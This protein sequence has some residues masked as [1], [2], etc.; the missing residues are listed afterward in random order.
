[1]SDATHALHGGTEH[2]PHM[3]PATGHEVTHSETYDHNRQPGD[4]HHDGSHHHVTSMTLLFGVFAALVVL[5]VATV[6]VT[7][8][9]FGYNANLVVAMV[10][11]VVKATLVGMYFMHLRWDAP[12]NGFV[13]VVS[14]MFVAIFITF[15]LLDTGAYSDALDVPQGTGVQAATQ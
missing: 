7:T 10:I 15:T 1:M 5:T 14:L 4:P 11:A 2:D 6:G 8:W 12:L 3:H 13:L 9:D